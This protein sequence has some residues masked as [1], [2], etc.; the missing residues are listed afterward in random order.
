L[1]DDIVFDI[2]LG[3]AF[4][5]LSAPW[6]EIHQQGNNMNE[7]KTTNPEW[8]IQ[9]ARCYKEKLPVTLIDDA[10]IGID[11]INQSLVQMGMKGVLG[12]QEWVA[13]VISLGVA[14]TGAYLLVMAILDPEPFSKIAFALG[15]GAL[16]TMGGGL[17]A[18]KVLTKT[19]PP[20]VKIGPAGFEIG[21]D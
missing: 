8:V 7:V 21:W 4:C 17:T 14:A 9:L 19:K 10:H 15:S 2:L 11:P 16:L 1:P 5:R 6:T 13:V 18:V 3:R 12:I 20:N